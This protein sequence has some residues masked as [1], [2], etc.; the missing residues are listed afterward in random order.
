MNVSYISPVSITMQNAASGSISDNF[1]CV[2]RANEGNCILVV[3]S[4][5]YYGAV[6]TA[7]S[8]RLSLNA[9]S[10]SQATGCSPQEI[11]LLRPRRRRRKKDRTEWQVP[12]TR[13]KS[14]PRGARRTE[15]RQVLTL[16]PTPRR[17]PP[18]TRLLHG[19]RRLR[20]PRARAPRAV[21]VVRRRS[22]D[23][24]AY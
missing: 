21:D 4:G 15:E 7:A 5:V 14:D 10:T 24:A 16:K 20:V 1:C 2:C 18:P 17:R 8:L 13:Q 9:A 12:F 22:R 3:V 19:A 6:S 11:E 23:G